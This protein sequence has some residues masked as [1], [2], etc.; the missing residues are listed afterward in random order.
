M[1]KVNLTLVRTVKKTVYNNTRA[2]GVAQRDSARNRAKRARR[3]KSG[4]SLRSIPENSTEGH[5][6]FVKLYA[7]GGS[8]LQTFEAE[9]VRQENLFNVLHVKPKAIVKWLAK[10]KIPAPAFF[11]C[12]GKRGYPP[13][14][15]LVEECVAMATCLNSHY[16]EFANFRENHIGAINSIKAA[17]SAVRQKHESLNVA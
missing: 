14:A 9:A 10:G 2:S 8:N 16:R 4:M 12:T 5:T 11:V 6:E 7:V 1:S 17:V 15:Y 3:Q 13:K